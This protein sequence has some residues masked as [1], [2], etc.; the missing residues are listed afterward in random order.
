[1]GATLLESLEAMTWN[2][3]AWLMR[4]I[5]ND[6]EIE[7]HGLMDGVEDINLHGLMDGVEDSTVED[8]SSQDKPL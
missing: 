7:L 3:S 5:Y 8:C 1:V 4:F 6:R 2:F